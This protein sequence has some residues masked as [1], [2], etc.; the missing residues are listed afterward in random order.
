MTE[1]GAWGEAS[2]GALLHARAVAHP[3]RVAFTFLADGEGDERLLT[4]GPSLP[5]VAAAGDLAKIFPEEPR[6]SYY[7]A[8]F[9]ARCVEP[10]LRDEKPGTEA[11]RRAQARLYADQAVALLRTTL[12]R[13]VEGM[14]RLSDEADIFRPLQGLVGFQE[15][16][17]ELDKKTKKP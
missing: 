15:V 13:G 12:R 10:A 11:D 17:Q 14:Q 3:D 9:V 16:M 4:Y 8:C 7:A 5:A 6:D 1:S 2:C